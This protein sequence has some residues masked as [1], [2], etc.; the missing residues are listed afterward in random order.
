MHS[1]LKSVY[2]STVSLQD[3]QL[4]EF[5]EQ[6]V[7]LEML[8]TPINPADLNM[9]QGNLAQRSTTTACVLSLVIRCWIVYMDLRF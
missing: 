1:L 5:D 6:S 7:F 8:A 9:V 4:P 2:P 3:Y